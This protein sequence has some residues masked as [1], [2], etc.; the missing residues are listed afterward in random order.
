M[1]LFKEIWD[2]YASGTTSHWEMESLCFYHGIHELA[3]IN[4]Y[5]YNIADFNELKSNEV[6]YYYNRRG[7]QLPVYKLYRII[8]TVIAKDD[9]K[10]TVILLTT[11][12][13]VGVKFTRDYYSMFKKQISQV[14][15]DG[16]KKVIE[17]S[18][19]KR[20]TMLM[21]TGYRRDDQFVAKTYSNS[22]THQ[23]Y[24]ITMVDGEDMKL[25]HERMTSQGTI[26]EDYDET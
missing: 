12:G 7:V 21:I 14:Q 3:D 25:Q 20:G 11:T 1:I 16:T 6:D 9:N 22:Q 15:S 2:K 26:E 4:T 23:L 10:H 18:W 8:G 13:V 5:K 24:K 19:F 17:K